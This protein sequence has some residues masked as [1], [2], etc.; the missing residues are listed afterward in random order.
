MARLYPDL[1]RFIMH[2]RRNHD[3]RWLSDLL[4]SKEG[5]FFID[6]LLP[7]I[8]K[9]G[10]PALPIHDAFCV[11]GSVAEHVARMCCE[12]AQ[13]QFGFEPKFKVSYSVVT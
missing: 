6:C 4:T 12:L 13:E 11:P 1:A 9:A 10:I 2:K 7:Q 3:V 8:V 5:S